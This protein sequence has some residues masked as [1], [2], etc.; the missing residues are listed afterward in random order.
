MHLKLSL[1]LLRVCGG[2]EWDQKV[3]LALVELSGSLVH[4]SVVA[5]W[6]VVNNR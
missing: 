2:Q 3:E 6:M 5:V 1:W 4:Y